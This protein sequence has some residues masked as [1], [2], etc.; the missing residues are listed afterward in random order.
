SVA[1][2]DA[3]DIC[4]G[5]LV[6]PPKGESFQ[7]SGR[8]MADLIESQRR[9]RPRAWA[10]ALGK[11][12]GDFPSLS[13]G[14]NYNYTEA[15]PKNLTLNQEQQAVVEALCRSPDGQ[16]IAGHMS[17][18]FAH[19]F[20]FAYEHACDR[21]RELHELLPDLKFPY[22]N[23]V[24]PTV[25]FNGGPQTATYE[26]AD[27]GNNPGTPCM[28]FVCG[29]YKKEHARFVFHDLNLY[30]DFP[31]HCGVLLSSAAVRHSNTALVDGETRYSIAMYMPG[32]LIRY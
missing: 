19:Y 26:H 24:Y 5:V 16:R 15:R 28:V 10:H 20:P 4:V 8:V 21:M 2:I 22:P 30:V 27:T 18:A 25:T 14:I 23:C 29:D 12:R 17:E 13:A 32:A 31:P 7:N 6:A 11:K 3:S 1:I 9:Q